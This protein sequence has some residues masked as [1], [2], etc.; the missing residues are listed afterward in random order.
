[1]SIILLYGNGPVNWN[2]IQKLLQ[3]ASY[4]DFAS[5]QKMTVKGT[6]C[7]KKEGMEKWL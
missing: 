5:G 6:V 7:G 1:M 4:Y 3:S 2:N